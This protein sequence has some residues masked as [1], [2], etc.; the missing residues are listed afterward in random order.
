MNS[1]RAVADVCLV[2]SEVLQDNLLSALLLPVLG[3]NMVG[4]ALGHGEPAAVVT[5]CTTDKGCATVDTAGA[6]ASAAR[7]S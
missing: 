1:R 4:G 3:W 6:C 7:N 2:R 5:V